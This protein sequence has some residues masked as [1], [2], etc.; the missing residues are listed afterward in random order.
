MPL[1]EFLSAHCRKNRFRK[2]QNNSH[3]L[4]YL[5]GKIYMHQ[6]DA[7]EKEKKQICLHFLVEI[8]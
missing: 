8:Y 7:E 6:C 1:W 5:R 2:E 3:H 4:I